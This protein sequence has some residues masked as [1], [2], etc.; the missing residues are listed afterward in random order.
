MDS[1]SSTVVGSI[2]IDLKDHVS[3]EGTKLM[4]FKPE[5]GTVKSIQFEMDLIAQ[6]DVT[7]TTKKS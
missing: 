1:D 4:E 6:T 2:E 5:G 3:N 7:I